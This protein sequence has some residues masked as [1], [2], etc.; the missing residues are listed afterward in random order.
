[1]D[2]RRIQAEFMSP[3]A[4]SDDDYDC[5]FTDYVM[6]PPRATVAT[7]L[8]LGVSP[9]VSEVLDL[10]TGPGLALSQMNHDPVLTA[11]FARLDRW[12]RG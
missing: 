9:F 5:D 6:F 8:L 4:N 12:D 3:F 11:F 7:H 2:H 1:M 10:N